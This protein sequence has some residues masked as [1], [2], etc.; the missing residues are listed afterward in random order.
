[1]NQTFKGDRGIYTTGREIGKGGEGSVYEV[2]NDD[3]LV[4]KLYSEALPAI[5]V[6]KLK[7]MASTASAQLDGYTA[8]VKDVVTDST[9]RVCGFTMKK[10]VN[11][12]PLH[13]LFGPMDRKKM[14]PD[15]GY[16]FLIHVARNLATA[17]HV[18]HTSGHV[19][20]DVNEG[21]ILVNS[22]GMIMLIDCDSFQIK[23]GNS[24]YFC[25]V[26]IPRYTSPELL[27]KTT[28]HEVV[29]TANT[30]SFSLAVIIFQL[31]FMGRHPFAGINNSK[32]DIDE[33]LAIKNH[34]FAYS[35]MNNSGK[36]SPP[37]DTYSIHD[38][39][40]NLREMFHKS[41]E[42]VENRPT[43]ADWVKE[44]D[45]YK[46]EL[47]ACKKSKIHFYPGWLAQC[48]WCNF[49]EKKNILYFLDDSYL[50]QIGTLNN[51]DSFVNGFKVATFNF[52]PLHFPT[53][54]PEHIIAKP[55]DAVYATYKWKHR[56]AV[57]VPVIVGI[58][59]VSVTPWMIGIG[60]FTSIIINPN[61]PWHKK[62]Q[63]EMEIREKKLQQIKGQLETAIKEYNSPKEIQSYNHKSNVLLQTIGKLKRLPSDLQNQKKDV[64]EKLY[65]KQLHSFLMNFD[66]R[67][68]DIPSFGAARKLAVYTAGIK[69]AS[70]V[71]K[72]KSLKIAGIGPAFEARLYGWQRQVSSKF[73]YHPDV[74]LLRN[75]FNKIASQIEQMKK[76]FE[77]EI[78]NQFQEM[79]NIRVGINSRQGQLKKF[80]DG[81]INEYFQA[82]LDR[83]AFKK[84][85]NT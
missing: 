21:N 54:S 64:E 18:C 70:D 78:K 56:I 82:Y 60:L 24:Y 38:I 25:E 9:G 75:E 32:M 79:E 23:N 13:T 46:A 1:M 51:I 77:H 15:K 81:A 57:S 67:N 14:F 19:I 85:A 49:V 74:T 59:L 7:M 58:C 45:L 5:K 35:I 41:F 26:G 76:H 72:L 42:S 65:D 39:R 30:D 40:Q 11:Y 20:G 55:I 71:S 36:L 29:R 62:I 83:D 50:D 3:K 6:R 4:L 63:E 8:W 22:Q 61:L 31:M 73:V 52:P 34:W 27:S 10:L 28:F 43:P 69:N 33:E 48:P 44:L 2:T 84:M 80:V 12:Y 53:V 47:I 16:N 17:F 37:T 68:Y 66:I